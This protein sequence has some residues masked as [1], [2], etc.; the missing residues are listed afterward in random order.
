MIHANSD[1]EGLLMTT[2][3]SNVKNDDLGSIFARGNAN[4]SNYPRHTYIEPYHHEE[5]T[6]NGDTKRK[7][8]MPLRQREKEKGIEEPPPSAKPVENTYSFQIA[9]VVILIVIIVVS[10]GIIWMCT[11]VGDGDF[12]TGVSKMFGSETTPPSCETDLGAP[13]L[14]KPEETIFKRSEILYEEPFP[15]KM[16]TESPPPNTRAEEPVVIKTNGQGIS[17]TAETRMLYDSM[18]G[19]ERDRANG[20]L[21]NEE[22]DPAKDATLNVERNQRKKIR[23]LF[24]E[25]QEKN[26]EEVDPSYGVNGNV[27]PPQ[28]NQNYEPISYKTVEDDVRESKK[29]AKELAVASNNA[30]K[31]IY[32]QKQLQLT[33]NSPEFE[34][35]PSSNGGIEFM[36]VKDQTYLGEQ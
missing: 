11:N 19:V 18:G 35:D 15:D 7:G 24:E 29:K 3:T 4:F 1:D 8:F 25:F 32:T 9:L 30:I 17:S 13:L 20:F 12:F 28:I 26:G 27:T 21:P 23:D 6:Y 2:D 22:Y 33:E 31:N 34:H 5:S 10:T 36:N 14:F 16:F